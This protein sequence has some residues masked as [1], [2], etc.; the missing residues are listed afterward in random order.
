M[1]N[2]VIARA[3]EAGFWKR[4]LDKVGVGG[5]LFAALCSLV[6]FA[7]LIAIYTAVSTPARL[8]WLSYGSRIRD[9]IH[10][11]QI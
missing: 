5:S 2:G 11:D 6:Q 3:S 9:E 8:R 7:V 1:R 10:D 4:H